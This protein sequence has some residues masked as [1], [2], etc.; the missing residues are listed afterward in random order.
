MTKGASV[1]D[2]ALAVPAEPSSTVSALTGFDPSRVERL[3][4]ALYWAR[5][6][7]DRDYKSAA[8][9]EVETPSTPHEHYVEGL[10]DAYAD[11]FNTVTEA[12][13]HAGLAIATEAGTA[14]TVKQGSV[15]EG[16]GPQDI[17][18]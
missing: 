4:R 16:A 9:R 2:R 8:E 17:A 5:G 11:A 18:Q 10:A 7:L 1:P 3:E 14:E 13:Q 15:H 6:Q 12:M